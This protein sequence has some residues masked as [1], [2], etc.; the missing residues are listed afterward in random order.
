[1]DKLTPHELSEQLNTL[2]KGK[3][4]FYNGHNEGEDVIIAFDGPK[5]DNKVIGLINANQ[6]EVDNF[7]E[8]IK[9]HKNE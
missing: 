2:Y 8:H 4:E 7:I 6:I 5:D 9:Q 3:Y 1:M